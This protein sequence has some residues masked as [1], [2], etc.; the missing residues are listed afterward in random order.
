MKKIVLTGGPC[1]G[2]S[3]VIEFVKEVFGKRV[4]IVPE[5]ATVL[6]SSGF[7]VPGRDIEWSLE[8]Q[9]QFQNTIVTLQ[10][11]LE[12]THRQIAQDSDARA[13]ICDR[14][15]LDGAAYTPGGVTEFCQLYGVDRQLAEDEYDLVIHLESLAVNKPELYGKAGN[16]NRFENA[17]EAR[18]LDEKT[19][20]AWCGHRNQIVLGGRKELS[21]IK[22]EVTNL[23][24][25]EIRP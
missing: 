19:K 25:Q 17:A 20:N 3:T 9:Y 15:L 22:A 8:W 6:L 21:D 16:E 4:V 2:K 7:P 14:G 5:A 1:A 10:R 12:V 11:S 18:E 24:T 13:L 23:I